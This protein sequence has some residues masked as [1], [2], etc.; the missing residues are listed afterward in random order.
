[1]TYSI[2]YSSRTGNTRQL[3]QAIRE[4]LP[5]GECLYFGSPDAQALAAERLYVG[6]WTDKGSCDE[7]TR[8]FLEKLEGK[9]VFLFGTAG[10]G[11][12]PEYF[13]RLLDRVRQALP[14]GNRVTGA[15]MC[16]G[17]MPASV[18]ERYERMLQSPEH[19]LQAE[20]MIENF[21]QALNHP[22]EDDLQRLK[23]AVSAVHAQP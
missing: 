16:Q 15:F 3:A 14:G 11:G 20:K 18:R 9:D 13:Q 4:A 21:D 17:H 6:F 19:K 8:A 2:V 5:T 12:A 10:F 7:D 23:Q 22:D 1:M